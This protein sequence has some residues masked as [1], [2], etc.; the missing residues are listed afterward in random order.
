MI[1]LPLQFEISAKIHTHTQH[2]LPT[3]QIEGNIPLVKHP[4]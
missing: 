4:V 2:E 1:L 3:Y